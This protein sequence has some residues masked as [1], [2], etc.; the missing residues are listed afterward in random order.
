MPHFFAVIGLL[1]SI[2]GRDV[3]G[4]NVVPHLGRIALA[5]VA[6]ASFQTATLAWETPSEAAAAD[7]AAIR[8]A[9]AAYRELRRAQHGARLDAKPTQFDPESLAQPREAVLALWRSV[10]D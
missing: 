6:A 9:A 2:R 1:E 7:V 8:A 10:F 4:R 3:R 5:V